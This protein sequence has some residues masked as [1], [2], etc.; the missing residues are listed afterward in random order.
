MAPGSEGKVSESLTDE[1]ERRTEAD[2][3]DGVAPIELEEDS[4][5]K[6]GDEGRRSESEGKPTGAVR[7]AVGG[8]DYDRELQGV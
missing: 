1:A 6:H 7:A 8:A 4:S 2:E 3:A 5:G